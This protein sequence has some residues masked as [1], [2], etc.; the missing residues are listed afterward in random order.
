[1]RRIANLCS[2]T[3]IL[4]SKMKTF[5]NCQYLKEALN[6]LRTKYADKVICDGSLCSKQQTPLAWW[7]SHLPSCKNMKVKMEHLLTTL[8][9]IIDRNTIFHLPMTRLTVSF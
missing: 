3:A 9:A 5:Q 2:P 7:P 8:L 1:M 6:I 4:K